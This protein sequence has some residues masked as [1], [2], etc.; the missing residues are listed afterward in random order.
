MVYNNALSSA[1]KLNHAGD[2]VKNF[3]P[4]IL[5]MTGNPSLSMS[6]EAMRIG[7]WDY[8]PKPYSGTQLQ[9]L[10]GRAAHVPGRHGRRARAAV[11]RRGEVC[12][13]G[14]PEGPV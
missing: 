6:I 10:L 13:L 2:H 11:V 14:G 3:R 7:A 4:S 5:L 8:L 1:L 12:A 9:L